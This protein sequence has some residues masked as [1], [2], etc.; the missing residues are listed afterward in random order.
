M[1]TSHKPLVIAFI[2]SALLLIAFFTL[3]HNEAKILALDSKWIAISLLPILVVLLI[4]GYIKSFKGFGIELEGRLNNPVTSVSLTATDAAEELAGDEKR[5][6]NYLHMLAER[7]RPH[8][9]YIS[10]LIFIQGRR[11]YYSAEIISEYMR[12]L[13]GLKYFEVR[14]ESGD[15]IALIPVSR[16]KQRNEVDLELVHSFISSLEDRILFP[17]F[18]PG[19][20]RN[21][22]NEGTSLVDAL[23]EIRKQNIAYIAVV[24]DENSFVG[25]LNARDI[26]KRIADEVLASKQNRT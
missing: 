22:V 5:S 11:N 20:I 10:R 23:R 8:N 4:G 16:F 13:S 12:V 24:S 25:L 2:I 26:E 21:K 14:E 7:G 17:L 15:F 1:K 18:Q 19:A 9:R 3:Q 6:L